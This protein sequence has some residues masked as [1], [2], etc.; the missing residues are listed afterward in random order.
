MRPPAAFASSA[1]L[2]NGLPFETLQMWVHFPQHT[3]NLF[4]FQH[5]AANP[6]IVLCNCVD[7]LP[8]VLF[9]VLSAELKFLFKALLC[10]NR[11]KFCDERRLELISKREK[12]D[13]AQP[14]LC[15]TLH[16]NRHNVTKLFFGT[17][18]S[19]QAKGF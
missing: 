13:E 18:T 11:R 16:C 7:E 12:F 19:H 5:F 1:R 9:Q 17:D 3:V 2:A 4:R 6:P 15:A 10:V 8:Q 14:Q